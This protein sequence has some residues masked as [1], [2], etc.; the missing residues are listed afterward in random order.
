MADQRVSE[1]TR[2]VDG[3]TLTQALGVDSSGRITIASIATSIVPGTG[4]TNLG[5]AEDAAHTTGD[6]GVAVWGVRNDTHTNGLSGADGD[7]TPFGLDASGKVG[8]R[9]TFAEDAAHTSG[10]LGIQVLAV[11]KDSA[12]A[13]AGTDGDYIPLTTDDSGQLRVNVGNTISV[14]FDVPT[15]PAWDI[16]N[17]ST[18]VNLAAGASGNADSADLASKKLRQ[19]VVSGSV[20]FKVVLSTLTNGSATACCVL[21]G[22][23]LNPVVYSPPHQSYMV[24]GSSGGADGFR[25]AITNLDVSETADFYASFAYSDN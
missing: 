2:I 14:S 5:K 21:F 6:T 10:D 3:S 12:T 25:A 17:V 4:A 24:S 11:R 23:P 8:I 22:G 15:N 1:V 18:P 7:Y 19:V 16:T 9:G 13:L 20:C